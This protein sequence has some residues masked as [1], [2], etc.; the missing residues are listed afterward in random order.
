MN[1]HDTVS[2]YSFRVFDV[3]AGA[4]SVALFKA[5]SEAIATRFAGEPIEGTREEVAR[6]DPDEHGC[7]RRVATGWGSLP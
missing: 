4:K 5:T 6:D 3:L 1:Q 2:V 7:Y